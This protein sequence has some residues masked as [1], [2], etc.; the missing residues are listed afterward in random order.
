MANE[1]DQSTI[2]GVF[3]A[4]ADKIRAK[5][6]TTDLIPAKQLYQ[7]VG[8][9]VT[10]KEGSSGCTATADDIRQGKTAITNNGTKVTGTKVIPAYTMEYGYI[11][12]D[13]SDGSSGKVMDFTIYTTNPPRNSFKVYG[14]GNDNKGYAS[15]FLGD[16][17]AHVYAQGGTSVHMN[18]ISEL[19]VDMQGST[20]IEHVIR[21][22]DSVDFYRVGVGK[23]MLNSVSSLSTIRDNCEFRYVIIDE[24]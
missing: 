8:D 10:I 1:P 3:K 16:V 22:S 7:K 6:G 19:S 17:K 5:N 9:I 24:D 2:G 15:L 20:Q 13:G 14:F 12:H 4:I 18:R 23:H 11:S 21:N